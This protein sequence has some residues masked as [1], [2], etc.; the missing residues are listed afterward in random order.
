MIITQP[1]IR[2]IDISKTFGDTL[3]LDRVT[4][5]LFPGEI[6]GLVGANGSGKTTLMNILCG[7]L[8]PDSG[9]IWV[10]GHHVTF[11]STAEAVSHGIR[12][13]PQSLEIYPSLSVLENIFIG[14]EMTRKIRIPR[15]MAWGKMEKA[16]KTLLEHVNASSIDPRHTADN[17]SGGQ[18]KAIVLARLLAKEAEVLVFDEPM[19]SLGVKQKERLLE[20]LASESAKGR[21]IVFISHDIDDVLSI[22]NRVAVLNNGRV[23]RDVPRQELNQLELSLQLTVA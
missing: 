1:I 21:S 11:R 16:A 17:L 12:M 4:L 5:N 20:I 10:Q 23:S 8:L 7:N 15:L 6:L 9:E 22:C 18:K 13:L 19:A 3:A 2:L 14:Q